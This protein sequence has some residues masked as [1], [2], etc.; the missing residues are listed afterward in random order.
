M[1][2]ERLHLQNFRNFK[3]F[4]LEIP[5]DGILRILGRNGTGKTNLLESIYIL[6]TSRSFRNRKTLKDCVR[7]QED[8]FHL[9]AE[10]NGVRNGMTFSAASMEKSFMIGQERVKILDFIRG[11]NIL[12]FSPDETQVFFQSQEVRR[13]LMDRYLSALRTQYLPKLIEY[14]NLRQKKVRILLSRTNRKKPL[15]E[16]ESHTFRELSEGISED[17]RWFI[18][19]LNPLFQEYLGKL[20]PKIQDSSLKYRKKQIP[21][22]YLEKELLQERVLYGC[23]KEELEILENGREVRSIFSN[24][25]KK[26]INLAIHFAFMEL[27]T[28]ETGQPCLVCLDDIESELDR[29]TLNNIQMI[30]E[31][32]KSQ[33][34]QTSKM[35]ELASERDILLA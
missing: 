17:R 26:V 11:K 3:D 27:L 13:A 29:Q 30:L 7:L 21:D 6:F 14:S 12:Y 31:E 32:T 16:V 23:H 24:G 19:Q 10:I 1:I 18:D 34:I 4:S 25:E 9:Q 8:F 15:L 33:V 22:Q 35:T 20:N 2:L 5:K 28:R